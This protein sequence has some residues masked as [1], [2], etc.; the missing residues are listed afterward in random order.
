M[1]HNCDVL[2]VLLGP[3]ADR[4]CAAY[5]NSLGYVRQSMG[6][7]LTQEH[8]ARRIGSPAHDENCDT[9]RCLLAL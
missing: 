1:H 8:Q 9:L 2:D 3:L 6:S 7:Q 5:V 4:L